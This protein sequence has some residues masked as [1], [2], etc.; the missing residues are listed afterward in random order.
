MIYA[1]A[2][3]QIRAVE[4]AALA[5]DG[6]AT[7][8]RRA[9]AAVA[10]A[11]AERTPAPRPGTRVALL[12]GSGNNGGDALYAG[13]MLRGRGMAVTAVLL[14]PDKAHPAGLA[15]LRRAG[16]RV[17]GHDDPG[18]GRLIDDADVIIDGV[19]GLAAT[20][21]LREPAAALIER[22]NAGHAL[23]V[24]VDL[25]SGI[26]PDTGRVSGPAFLAD[27]TVTFGGIKIGLLLADAQTGTIVCDPIGM[28]MSPCPPQLVAMT[29]GAVARLIPRPGPGA[30]KFTG[31]L[32]GILAGSPGYPGAPVLCTGG[33]VRTRPGM[34]RYAGKQA[35]AVLARWPEVVAADDPAKVGQVQAWVVGPGLGTDG[36]ATS[37]LRWALS[38]DVPVLVDADGLTVLAQSP[39]LL[40]DRKRTGRA[41]VLTPHDREFARVFPDI[42][43]SDR[44]AAVRAAAKVS[45]ATVLLKGNRTLVASPDGQATVNLTGTSW[46]ATAGSG[47]VLSGVI[48]SLLASGLTP[49][50]AAAAG[51]H[52][53]GR[54]GQR[55]EAAG[56]AGAQALWD[57]LRGPSTAAEGPR[58]RQV[59]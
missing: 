34:V 39:S 24:A 42:D 46:L 13:A 4:K 43:L 14:S 22:A 29:D 45:G 21:P 1:Y 9:S 6:D 23:R 27:V 28:D 8:M 51:A 3:E 41:T 56:E 58:H 7:L 16:G 20:P 38:Q 49:L 2:V 53:H 5:R 10:L 26:E 12:V 30:D 54:A 55:A 32:V 57:H 52:L 15:A 37:Q 50:L 31:G 44:L 11:V 48:G 19:V 47:D 59:W 36:A 35:S 18:V 17:H 25:P 33:A 40:A